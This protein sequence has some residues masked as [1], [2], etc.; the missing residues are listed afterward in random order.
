VDP[1][2]VVSQ[3]ERI[4]NVWN[5]LLESAN[6]STFSGFKQA[7]AATTT[8]TT[9]TV[10]AVVVFYGSLNTLYVKLVDLSPL[11]KCFNENS[12]RLLVFTFLY[13]FCKLSC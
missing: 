6:F 8:T 12:F 7:A 9:T 2:K 10:A 13:M 3:E 1:S 4:V 5:S 11:L